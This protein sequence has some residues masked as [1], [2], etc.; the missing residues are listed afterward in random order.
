MPWSITSFGAGLAAVM[1]GAEVVV[2]L[3]D[4]A[5]TGLAVTSLAFLRRWLRARRCSSVRTR[6][7]FLATGQS[8]SC[9]SFSFRMGISTICNLVKEVMEVLWTHDATTLGLNV[10]Y[11][12]AKQ[13]NENAR[14]DELP[15]S[16]TYLP[17]FFVGDGAYPIQNNLMNP[18][19]GK[20]LPVPKSNFNKHLSIVRATVE[21]AFG[22]LCQKWR[23]F[24]TT[25]QQ[26][27]ETAKLIVKTT[28]ILHNVILEKEAEDIDVSQYNSTE[29]ATVFL[30]DNSEC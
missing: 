7:I 6:P 19:P 23:I 12:T 18:Y 13:E 29:T 15:K 28:C 16:R 11:R 2:A 27:S 17:Y 20:K 22:R 14:D 21:C 9:L 24:Y 10:L 8:Y 5:T 4:W 25:I 30:P 3:A 26:F 1:S